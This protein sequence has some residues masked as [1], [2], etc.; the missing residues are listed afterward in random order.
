MFKSRS[1]IEILH[2]PIFRPQIRDK[3]LEALYSE[4]SFVLTVD[5]LTNRTPSTWC[6]TRKG[7]DQQVPGDK[8]A[9]SCTLGEFLKHNRNF[10]ALYQSAPWHK[11]FFENVVSS[12]IPLTIVIPS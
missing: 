5:T 10:V 11:V 6:Q 2:S 9:L 3:I 7:L 12:L 4:G 8:C 1:L